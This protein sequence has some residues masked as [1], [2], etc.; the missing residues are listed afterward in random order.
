MT[1]LVLAS[2]PV[3]WWAAEDRVTDALGAAASDALGETVTIG[4]LRPTLWP[5]GALAT[6]VALTRARDGRAVL[7]LDALRVTL[8]RALPDAP[9]LLPGL[10]LGEVRLTGLVLDLPF[11]DTGAL[12]LFRDRPAAPARPDAEEAAPLRA[13]PLRAVRL[14]DARLTA[15]HPRAEL[16]LT[17]AHL[18]PDGIDAT[19]RLA[20]GELVLAGPIT[21]TA[22]TVDGPLLAVDG[23]ALDLGPLVLR[24]RAR[25]TLQGPIDADLGLTA[26]LD[27]LSAA[28]EAPR[29]VRGRLAV[30]STVSGSLAAPIA[31]VNAEVQG[32]GITVVGLRVPTLTYD[33]GDAAVGATV[34]RDEAQ[35]HTL[36]AA[37]ADGRLTGHATVGLPEL[38]AREV[39]LVGD[40]LSLARLLQALGAAPT[41]WVDFRGDADVRATG[42]LRPLDL[43]GPVHLDLRDYVVAD[44]PVA[45]ERSSPVLHVPRAR[46]HGSLHLH[47]DHID[48]DLGPVALGRRGGLQGRVDV[49]VGFKPDGPLDVRFDLPR[50]DLAEVGPLGGAG[51]GGRG[52]VRGRVWGPFQ[53]LRAEATADIHDFRAVG[54][55]WGHL[56]SRV[57]SPDLK[58]IQLPAARLERGAT[59][60]GGDVELDF[61]DGIALH[62]AVDTGEARL[63]DLLGTVLDVPGLTGDLAATVTLDGP[64]YDLD[65]AIDVRFG[66]VDVFG[67]AFEEGRATAT[68]DGGLFTLH[69]LRLVRGADEALVASGGVG[70]AWATDLQLRTEGLRLDTLNVLRDLTL[71]VAGDLSAEARITGSL[72]RPEP[73]GAITLTHARYAGRDLADSLVTFRTRDGVLAASAAL[74]GQGAVADATLDLWTDNAWRVD[75]RATDLALDLLYP[76]AADG[77]A[78]SLTATADLHLSGRATDPAST[79]LALD[80]EGAQATWATHTLRTTAPASLRLEAGRW[81]FGGLTLAGGQT[82][83]RLD[84]SRGTSL[85][86]SGRGQLDL[87]L[88]RAVVPGLRRAQGTALVRIQD[89]GR[90]EDG[91]AEVRVSAR[92]GVLR[93]DSL[94]LTLTGL[95]VD[96]IASQDGILLEALDAEAGG[97]SLHAQ[98]LVR[99]EGWAPTRYDLDATVLDASVQWLDDL[100]AAIGDATLR[101]VGPATRPLLSGDVTIRDMAFTDRI[102]W[103]DALLSFQPSVAT[104]DAD[105]ASDEDALFAM[106][107]ALRADRTV[108]LDNNVARGVGAASLRVVGDTSR[109]GLSGEVVLDGAEAFLQDRPF[110]I[111]R[112]RIDFADPYS[113]D[114]LID[115]DLTTSIQTTRQTYQVRYRITGRYSGWTAEATS[116]PP[117]DQGDVNALIWFGATPDELIALGQ[118]QALAS[119]I[120]GDLAQLLLTDLFTAAGV[121]EGGPE[122]APIDRFELTTG[123][124]LR[125]DWTLDTRL[126]LGKR[127]RQLGDIELL[128]ELDLTR[129]AN[130][131][132]RLQRR[133]G[134]FTLGAWYGTLERQPILP[135]NGALGLD[136]SVRAEA[137]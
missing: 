125:G 37:W 61:R 66:A 9:P 47:P 43:R 55:A 34:T 75:G 72:F 60:Y 29:S 88:L 86:L 35:I 4:G 71:P 48:L 49:S 108:E 131:V 91:G 97:G 59:V 53:G 83:F 78:V 73:A 33:I 119:A 31:E 36:D 42:T 93:H 87:D 80:V 79:T 68:M 57:R 23:L 123:L 118:P 104:A 100:P 129:P 18:G 65:G 56:R 81:T 98:G 17:V 130:Q 127:F 128:A 67:E 25:H 6:D 122:A 94:P 124:T 126:L 103:E 115:F 102:D 135:I 76:V 114:P 96:A 41:P 92:D 24:G 134:P 50:A 46:I 51:L 63:E 28:L 19:A 20:A 70:R 106:D 39:H 89:F 107:I 99:A 132:W 27:P 69:D 14:D 16:A 58:R 5:P 22:V 95:S 40:N 116:D 101:F 105:A 136:I 54:L 21:A 1:L 38:D 64:L 111:R 52:W 12:D 112:G 26:T 137:R 77:G 133:F 84:P 30:T 10:G 120:A 109:P 110:T 32:L 2:L 117:L 13:L 121:N 90:D 3:A 85:R 8:A 113:F 82:R 45:A 44:G 15:R 62:A 11:D 7:Q 74:L